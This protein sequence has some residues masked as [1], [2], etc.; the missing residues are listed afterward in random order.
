VLDDADIAKI[1]D[2]YHAW[3]NHDGGYADLP[4][5]CNAASRDEIAGHDFVLTPG[6]YVGAEAAQA[7]D[8]PI[9]E[10]IE[11]LK[12]ELFAEFDRGSDLKTIV[13]ARLGGMLP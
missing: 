13:R 7:D 5:F 1:T 2:T 6:R 3:R 9:D 4:G 10:K 8:E 12:K 11:R